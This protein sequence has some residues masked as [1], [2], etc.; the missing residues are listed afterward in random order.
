MCSTHH[1]AHN[2]YIRLRRVFRRFP[3]NITRDNDTRQFELRNV[4]SREVHLQYFRN[5]LKDTRDDWGLIIHVVDGARYYVIRLNRDI[6]YNK[7][8]G[9][10]SMLVSTTIIAWHWGY[11]RK[12]GV[13]TKMLFLCILWKCLFSIFTWGRCSNK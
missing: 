1:E 11:F 13:R 7:T 9:Q 6:Q 12:Y 5:R 2:N 10:I 4:E 3:F 8:H